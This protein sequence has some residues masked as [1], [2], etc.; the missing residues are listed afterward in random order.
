[1]P[2]SVKPWLIP[3]VTTKLGVGVMGT[4]PTST[5]LVWGAL[6]S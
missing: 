2:P 5:T 3:L 6:L 1:M 4:G